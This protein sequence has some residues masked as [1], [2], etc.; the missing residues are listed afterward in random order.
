VKIANKKFQSI[1]EAMLTGHPKNVKEKRDRML[2]K[3]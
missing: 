1:Y 3:I 2:G